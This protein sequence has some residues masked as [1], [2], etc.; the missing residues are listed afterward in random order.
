MSKNQLISIIKKASTNLIRDK[1]GNNTT[2]DSFKSPFLTH[3][4]PVMWY[5]DIDLVN[6]GQWLFAIFPYLSMGHFTENT[7][8][9]LA[10]IWWKNN[11]QIFYA[12]AR[13]QWVK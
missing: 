2:G 1:N 9:M 6:I 7:R 8:N 4:G 3:C 5:G 11:C 10:K 13:E 12:S